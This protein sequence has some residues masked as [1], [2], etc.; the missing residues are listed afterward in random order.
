MGK[1]RT[2]DSDSSSD[3]D[4]SSNSE[5]DYSDFERAPKKKRA[6]TVRTPKIKTPTTQAHVT[7]RATD[8]PLDTAD[9]QQRVSNIDEAVL[10]R[11]RKALALAV[12]EGTGE[13]EAPSCPGPLR[14]D[15]ELTALSVSQ[16]DVLAHET[17]AEKLQRAGQSV[18]SI[19]STI[20]PDKAVSHFSWTNALAAAMGTF[21]GCQSYS[22]AFRGAF[23]KIDWTFYGLAEQ[24]VAAA[25]AFEMCYNLILNWSLKP[26][27][28]KG[29]NVRNCYC[30]GVAS[31]LQKMAREDKEKDKQRAVKKELA[32][33]KAR[34]AEEAAEDKSRLDRLKAPKEEEVKPTPRD[35]KVK[36][37]EVEDEDSLKPKVE[38][39]TIAQPDDSHDYDD[40]DYGIGAPVYETVGADFDAADDVNN[41]LDLDAELERSKTRDRTKR[42]MP[43]PPPPVIKKE[44][45]EEE[46]SPWNSVSQLIQ[47]R[48]TSIAIGDDYLK[49]EGI[50]LRK[51]RKLQ[52]LEFKDSRSSASYNRGREDARKIDVRQRQI[53]D[54]D[55][56]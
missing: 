29:I 11:I 48:E 33:I 3:H 24:T 19:K 53:K 6:R 43:P 16:A 28:G 22:T 5:E 17:D 31:G 1:R 13:Q 37:E 39:V 36:V 51:G 23:P 44:E 10:G 4:V 26:E 27:V 41:L 49:K 2:Y 8:T 9:A 46:E 40:D 35:R 55:M 7:I 20:S 15:F 25:H 21:F 18:V 12:H 56:E 54:V 45:P 14:G 38:S 52:P 47:F 30:S 34:E 32:L 50:K 42:S